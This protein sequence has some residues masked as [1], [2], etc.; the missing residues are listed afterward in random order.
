LMVPS[1]AGNAASTDQ[2]RTPTSRSIISRRPKAT[3]P[4]SAHLVRTASKGV[5]AGRWCCQKTAEWAESTPRSQD[6]LAP[7]LQR[8]SQWQ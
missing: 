1:P 2:C 5:A 6:S 3:G 4:R 7:T 8:G